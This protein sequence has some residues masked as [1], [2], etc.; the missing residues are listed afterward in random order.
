MNEIHNLIYN[1]IGTDCGDIILD[2]KKDLDE[3]E[4]C[5]NNYNKLFSMLF[6]Q[7]NLSSGF[8]EKNISFKCPYRGEE[9]IFRVYEKITL[10]K[11]IYFLQYYMKKDQLEILNFYKMKITVRDNYGNFN[12]DYWLTH[13][14]Y[15]LKKFIQLNYYDWLEIKS[16]RY[17][18]GLITFNLFDNYIK[19]QKIYQKVCSTVYFWFKNKINRRW[20]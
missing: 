5:L 13:T 15:N 19:K 7:M 17:D 4:K 9:R 12:K 2:Y 14:K 20:K 3:Y 8:I 6:K 16:I 11:F 1:K 18:N 10:S